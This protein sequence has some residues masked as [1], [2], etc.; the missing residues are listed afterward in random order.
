LKIANKEISVRKAMI[1]LKKY[2]TDTEIMFILNLTQQK[3]DKEM[4]RL[5]NLVR[6][7]KEKGLLYE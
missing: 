7:T 3:F 5:K 2:H 6:G 1:K 4:N